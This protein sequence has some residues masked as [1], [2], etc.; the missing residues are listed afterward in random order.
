MA[1]IAPHLWFDREAKEAAQF[2]ASVFPRSQVTNV[3]TLHNTPSGDTDVVSFELAGQPFMAISAGPLFKFNPSISFRANCKSAA[4]A[5][6]LRKALLSR[7][8]EDK[9]GLSWQLTYGGPGNQMIT[10]VLTFAGK[11]QE[12][13]R[14]YASVFNGSVKETLFVIAGMEFVAMDGAGGQNFNEAISFLILCKDQQE[15]DH[16]WSKLSAVPQAEQCGWLK[17][18]FGVSWQVTS[19]EMQEM[20]R[21]GT[22][23]Q[24]DRVTK[25]F[26]PMKK[27]DVAKLRRAFQ[28]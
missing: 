12:A 11:A 1:A 3:T 19:M 28:G 5:N 21:D 20:L 16:Y 2:Y 17:D 26:L 4:E 22:R 6:A 18:K 15:I 13:A 8:S 14:F 7:G 9:Y 23:Q 10:P 24:I 25:A 27:V